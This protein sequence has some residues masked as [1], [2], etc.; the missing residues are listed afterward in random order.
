[1]LPLEGEPRVKAR[2]FDEKRF[3]LESNRPIGSGPELAARL[4]GIVTFNC[5]ELTYEVGRN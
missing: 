4:A 2:A 1:V 3:E 5:V